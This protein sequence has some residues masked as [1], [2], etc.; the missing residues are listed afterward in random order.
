MKLTRRKT[1]LGLLGLSSTA[2]LGVYELSDEYDK[3]RGSLSRRHL[4][5]LLTIA[6][7]VHP[8]EPDQFETIL[9]GYVTG[10]TDSR[11]RV[12]LGTL[13][14]LDQVSYSQLGI[15]FR[16]LSASEATLLLKALGVDRVQ[17]SPQG[18][19]AERIRFHLVNSV[20][21]A[22]LTDPVGTNVLG[23]DNPV[24]HP[25]GFSSYTQ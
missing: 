4:E 10:L 24:G 12:L 16:S 2:S 23:I 8:S 22:V 7:V 9:T 13:A 18:P 6:D 11:K 21:Y 3:R 5:G 19:L 1:L 15:P 20:L 17:S 25:G 14:E